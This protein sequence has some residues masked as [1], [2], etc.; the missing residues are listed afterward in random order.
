MKNMLMYEWERNGEWLV[1]HMKE[2]EDLCY[3]EVA[4]TGVKKLWMKKLWI[5]TNPLRRQGTEEFFSVRTNSRYVFQYMLRAEMEE[6]IEKRIE[7][8]M[9]EMMNK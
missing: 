7:E 1:Q 4:E 9:K 8:K 5:K 6:K 3:Q 2:L